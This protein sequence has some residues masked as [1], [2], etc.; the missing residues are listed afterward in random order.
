MLKIHLKTAIKARSISTET[1]KKRGMSTQN[2][3]ASLTT[4][5]FS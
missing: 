1:G 4:I 2:E 5:S 3:H